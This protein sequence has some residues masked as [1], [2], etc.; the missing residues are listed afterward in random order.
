MFRTCFICH[1]HVYTVYKTRHSNEVHLKG[2][3]LQPLFNRSEMQVEKKNPL[4][5]SIFNI[6]VIK[7]CAS[8]ESIAKQKSN[9]DFQFYSN[10]HYSFRRAGSALYS[11]HSLYTPIKISFIPKYVVPLCGVQYCAITFS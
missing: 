2:R 4:S 6:S 1:T 3:V 11:T 7:C 10:K 9:H 5:R 8:I